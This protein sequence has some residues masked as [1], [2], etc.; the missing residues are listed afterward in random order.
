MNWFSGR[1]LVSLEIYPEFGMQFAERNRIMK[2]KIYRLLIIAAASVAIALPAAAEPDSIDLP[3]SGRLVEDNGAPVVGPVD[4]LVHFYTSETAVT[5]IARGL[6]FES[7]PLEDG[8]FQLKISLTAG[9]FHKIFVGVGKPTWIQI[10]DD[11][12]GKMYPRQLLG[13]MPYALKVPVDGST[14]GWNDD[15]QLELRGDAS[16]NKVAGESFVTK[17]ATAGQVLAWDKTSN[18][19]KPASVASGTVTS[20]SSGAGLTG[21]VIT[22][23]G[24]LGIAND[25]VTGSMLANGAVTTPK[26]GAGAVTEVT[27]ANEAV[28]SVK[29]KDGTIALV[30][31]SP[32]ACA[33]NEI[34]KVNGT[35]TGFVCATVGVGGGDLINGGNSGAV[36]VGSNDANSLTFET[37]NAAAMTI[38]SAGKVGIGTNAPSGNLSVS[39]VQYATGTASQSLTTVTG[40]G[41]TFTLAM[42]GSQLAFANGVSAGTVTAFGS[43]TSLTVS[44]SQTVASQAYSINYAGLN[45]TSVGHVGI[46]TTTPGATLDIAGTIKI[47]DGSQGA[48]KI[49]TSDATGLANWASPQAT[50]VSG[51]SAATSSQTLAN[52]NFAQTWNWDGLNTGSGLNIGSSSITSGTLFNAAS[53]STAMT[54]TIGNFILSGDNAANTGSV[55]KATVAGVSSAAVPLMITNGGSGLSFRVNDDGSDSDSTPFVISNNGSVGIGT[56]NPL[57]SLQIISPI[58]NTM[59]LS[60]STGTDSSLTVGSDTIAGKTG[61]QYITYRNL[62]TAANAWMVGMDDDETFR[63]AYGAAG[64]ITNGGSIMTVLQNGKVGIGTIAPYA[65]LDVSSIPIGAGAIIAA[66]D[67][68]ASATVSSFGG[69]LLS[70]GPLPDALLGKYTHSTGAAADYSAFQIRNDS[71]NVLFHIDLVTGGGHTIGNVGIGITTPSAPLHVNED[72]NGNSY[73]VTISNNATVGGPGVGLILQTPNSTDGGDRNWAIGANISAHGT[74]EFRTSAT[75]SGAPAST[76]MTIAPSGYVGIGTTAPGSALE[77]AGQVKITGGVPGAGKVLTSDAVGLASWTVAPAGSVSG[78]SS[79]TASQTLANTD[80]SQTWNWDTVSTG[81]GLNLGSS[82]VT[83]GTLFNAASTSTAMTG[84]LGNF[85]LSGDNAANTG[86]VLKATVAGVSSAAVPLMITNGGT[87]MSFRVNDNGSDSDATPFVVDNAGNVGIGTTAPIYSLDVAGT[88]HTF[89]TNTIIAGTTYIDLVD[90]T[91][92]PASAPAAGTRPIGFGST[93]RTA[94]ASSLAN[95]TS[96]QAADFVA[97]HETSAVINQLTAVTNYTQND[98]GTVNNG[99]SETSNYVQAGSGTSVGGTG[100]KAQ[101]SNTSTGNITSGNGLSSS[102]TNSGA[103]T[104]TN[105]KGLDTS[106]IRSSGTVTNGYGLYV[107][108]IQATNKWSVYANDSSAP[109]YFAG[110][111]GI[112][113]TAPSSQL[114]VQNSQSVSNTAYT[115]ARFSVYDTVD[116]GSRG[117]SILAPTR[118]GGSIGLSWDSSAPFYLTP[119]TGTTALSILNSGNVGIGTTTPGSALEVAGQVKITGGA[120]GSGKVLT[121]DAAGLASWGSPAS[122]SVSGLS[123]ASAIGTVDNTNYAQNWN[124]STATT[125]SPMT[126]AANALTTGSLLNITS[127]NAT[128]NST[129]GLL[130]V[131]NTGAS[132]TGI[133]ARIQSSSAAGSGLTILANGNVGI[134]TTNPVYS[135]QLTG[136]NHPTLF[137]Q[138]TT[139]GGPTIGFG[140][141]GSDIVAD[142]AYSRDVSGAMEFAVGGLGVAYDKMVILASG[143]VGIGTTAPTN[144]LDILKSQNSGTFLALANADPGA[145]AASSFA[146][147]SNAGSVQMA[148]AS[149]AGGGFASLWNTANTP[150]RF[151]TNNAV[152]MTIASSG[153][154]GIGTTA[155]TARLDTQGSIGNSVVLR[156]QNN[157][158]AGIEILANAGNG[159]YPYLDFR[160]SRDTLA[161]PAVVADGDDLM[162]IAARGYDYSSY[163]AGAYIKGQVDGNPSAS[164][165]PGRLTFWTSPDGVNI[166]IERLRI[167]RDG[168]VGIGTTN[169]TYPLE[170]AAVGTGVSGIVKIRSTNIANYAQA[171]FFDSSNNLQGFIGWANASSATP[172]TFYL[173]TNGASPVQFYSNN[174]VGMTLASTGNVGIGTTAPATNLELSSSST[175]ATAFRIT[176]TDAGGHAY[177]FSTTGSAS[178]T[179]AAGNFGVYDA[180]ALAYRML[181]NASGNVGIGTTTP[182]YALDTTGSIRAT[183]AL[184]NSSAVP[185]ISACGTTPPVATAGSNNNAGQ[186]TLGTGATAACTVTFAN[187]FPNSAFCTVTPATN[188]TGTYYISTQSKSLFTV[189]LGTGTASVKFNYSCGGN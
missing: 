149:T 62:D 99:F 43:A 18:T 88:F 154:V 119:S 167:N 105:A 183:V 45:V 85:V 162:V 51:L 153:N 129:N 59:T 69:I 65:P 23:E 4:M 84:T 158:D 145:S 36:V 96:V 137:I 12:N 30:D 130:N 132:T 3:Y 91:Y 26:I 109:S 81:S 180:T 2:S 77:V 97:S 20:I 38:D 46:G 86:S 186:F 66:K 8:V 128:L 143:N 24:T 76:S 155:P 121:S 95:V 74:L 32:G 146:A 41:T 5:P 63:L 147:S 60:A 122:G 54:G 44:T 7:V 111:V 103:G 78:L 19:W 141:N 21:G 39:P 15:G 181:I 28:T 13:A 61:E 117:L 182:A 93:I 164:D 169:P 87:G 112:G 98:T 14:I 102:V 107:G 175:T 115:V 171:D 176:N 31:L 40:V 29:I 53:S 163:S 80:F 64:E 157:D 1:K 42:V 177:S 165:M 55:I 113:T 35:G 57:A 127:S 133:V 140:Y 125:Q 161:A 33:A 10:L 126:M 150:L 48:G 106:I 94:G 83:S 116:F 188:Y 16:V 92:N 22:G 142:I 184:L 156:A 148:I 179:G 104:I 110:N 187:A 90:S 11:T 82:S 37:N 67:P 101:V 6:V 70:S 120:P 136:T 170:L 168:N 144:P 100:V 50:S 151:A 159:K 25:G 108:S 139:N 72:V 71:S 138:D 52:N 160:R 89:T 172:N 118:S 34:F 189:T 123:G 135:M 27:I 68:V 9:E 75:S 173:G 17:G 79:A 174:A 49:L 124:W 131:A 58:E 56:T 47:T 166:P 178:S 73:P 185:T 114:H 134:G 152:M